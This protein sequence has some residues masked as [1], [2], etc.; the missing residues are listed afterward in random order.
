[1]KRTILSL[2]AIATLALSTVSMQAQNADY[3]WGIGLHY[4]LFDYGNNVKTGNGQ[5]YFKFDQMDQGFKVSVSRYLNP[6][7][8]LRL[9]LAIGDIQ[10]GGLLTESYLQPG[11]D[12]TLRYKTNNG[13]IF[14]EDASIAPFVVAGLG[15]ANNKYF[16]P[17]G[18][19]VL[20]LGGGLNIRLEK[21]VAL[22]IQSV[23]HFSTDEYPILDKNNQQ[24]AFQDYFQHSVGL[25]FSFGKSDKAPVAEP[26]AEVPVMADRDMD[27]IED[28]KDACPDVKGTAAFNGCPDTDGDG[29]EDSKDKCPNIAGIAAF[30]GCPDSDGDGI[31]NSK[32]KCPTIAGLAQFEGCPDTDG[33]GVADNKDECPNVAGVL[34]LNGCPDSDRD[35]VADI[36]DN[37]PQIPGAISNKGCPEIKVEEKAKLEAAVKSIQFESGKDVIKTISYS[38]LNDAAAIIQKYDGYALKIYG[39]TD[40]TGDAVK[41]QDLSERRA[42]AVSNYL[43][44]KGVPSSRIIDVKGFGSTQPIADNATPAGRTQNRR[45]EIQLIPR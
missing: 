9:G 1:M 29:I 45:T 25:V 20:P 12:L 42:L 7:L 17:A 37:C 22:Q 2:V 19:I 38:A 4:S 5:D 3:K 44:G 40:N 15:F 34:A 13:Y 43:Q 28:S 16:T 35:G 23:M 14:K 21:N 33:D 32:D 6:S 8:D 27:G 39:H 31:E 10:F 36:K 41:N 11:A 26:V 30:E 18:Q 24:I